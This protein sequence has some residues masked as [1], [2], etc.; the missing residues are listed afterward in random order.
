[1][2]R[3]NIVAILQ[4]LVFA[5]LVVGRTI[6]VDDDGP[7]DFN[8]IQAAIDDANDGDMVIVADG[9]YTGEGNRDIDFKG[10]AI[11]VQSENGPE[12]CIIDCNGTRAEGHRGFKFV[13]GEGQ[14]SVL[15]GFTI[16]NGYYH[17]GWPEGG[18]AICCWESSPL[19]TN[20]ILRDNI[21]WSGGGICCDESSPTISN[22]TI[23]ENTAYCDGGGI[24][25]E[26]NCSLT[27]INCIISRNSAWAGGG[28]IFCSWRSNL[29]IIDCTISENKAKMGCGGGICCRE[30]YE[31]NLTITNCTI[32][33]NTAAGE[34][35]GIYGEIYEVLSSLTI[36]NCIICLLYTSPSPRD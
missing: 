22:C 23:G 26:E 10:K 33:N 17:E 34:G 14:N 27:I 24:C 3:I 1:M 16:T 35:G 25:C 31:S 36:T 30:G 21:A 20:C 18:A 6:F 5:S 9:V 2:N 15:D 4:L 11:T 13:S 32:S 19:I 29:T 8:N 28:G 7:A 12:N